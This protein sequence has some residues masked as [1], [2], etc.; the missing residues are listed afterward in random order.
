MRLIVAIFFLPIL[1]VAQD[2]QPVSLSNQKVS[3]YLEAFATVEGENPASL[4]KVLSFLHKLS[5]KRAKFK[6]EQTFLRHVFLKTHQ[7]FLKEYKVYTTFNDLLR[8]GNYNCLT[9]T[10]LY[11]LILEHLGLEYEIIETNYHIFLLAE[12]SYGQVLLESTDPLDG[13]VIKT[14]EIES[15]ISHYRQ[16]PSVDSNRNKISYQFKASLYNSVGL[17]G[18]HGLLYY[19]LAVDAYNK[20]DLVSTINYLEKASSFYNSQRLEEFSEI[21]FLTVLESKIKTD[22]KEKLLRR[23][24]SM[25]DRELRIVASTKIF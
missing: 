17:D 19:N 14:Q 5:D 4:D 22:I 11:A 10:A 25:K 8:E 23:I 7:Q 9:A 24:Q 6:N 18:I 20:Q 21:V 15:K 1:A 2:G 12:T 3:T 16:N 13:F